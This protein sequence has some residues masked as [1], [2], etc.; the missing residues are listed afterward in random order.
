LER[1]AEKLEEFRQSDDGKSIYV[2]ECCK[3]L[4]H[5]ARDDKLRNAANELTLQGA[6]LLWAAIEVLCRDSFVVYLNTHPQAAKLFLVQ[7]DLRKRFEVQY[8]PFE[9]LLEH[10]FDLSA[11]MGSALSRGQDLSDLETM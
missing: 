8:L 7:P 5:S 11:H 9:A 6:V 10:N 4:M 1:A 2:N 3:F